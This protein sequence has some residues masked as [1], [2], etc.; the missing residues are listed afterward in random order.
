MIIKYI[1]N[2]PMVASRRQ[3][4]HDLLGIRL[5][6]LRHCFYVFALRLFSVYITAPLAD[7]G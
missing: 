5:R 2:E 4:H 1:V 7:S 3:R 6:Q